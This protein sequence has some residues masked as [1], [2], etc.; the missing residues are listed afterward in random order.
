MPGLRKYVQD[1][2]LPELSQGEPPYDGIA[3]LWFDSVD[4]FQAALA[5]PEGQA[6][7][8]DVPNFLEADKVRAVTV[9]EVTIT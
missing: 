2:V 1:H 9:E 7:L 8:A 5:S 4:A 6:T 3:E